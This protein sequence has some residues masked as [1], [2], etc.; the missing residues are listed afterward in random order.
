MDKA[1]QLLRFITAG[2]VDDGKSTLIGHLLHDSKS[3]FED[4][5][6]AISKTSAKRG[7]AAVDFSLLTDGLQAEREQGITI[8]VAY[9]YFATPKRKFI[10][11]D[12]PGHEQY[13]RNMVTAASTANLVVI[14]VDARKGVLVQTRRHTY[15]ASLV[16]IPHIVLAVNKMD[17]VEYSEARFSEICAEYLKFAAQLGLTDITC[18]P[19]SALVG[20][21][22]VD[23]GDNMD[24]YQGTT[25]M[26][27]LENIVI[28]HDVNTT[29]FRY[30]V[31]WVCRPQTEEHHDFRG[32]MG[33]IEAGEI[34]VG[35][36][37][38]VLPSGRTSKVKEIVT[39]DGKLQRAYAPQSVTLTLEDEIDISRGDMFV[40]G[41]AKPQVA[42]EF[43]AMLCWLSETP[44]NKNRKYLVKHTTRTAKCLFSSINYRVDVNTLEQHSTAMLNMNDIARVEIKVQQPLVFDSYDTDRATG[45]FIVIDE[46]TNNTVAAGMI[47]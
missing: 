45:S 22:L 5:F 19:I 28:D 24:W 8:D 38:T 26:N 32:F 31:Q 33:R 15:L 1:T 20:D 21:M 47:S 46:A 14:L 42:K 6:S 27:L 13:T 3:I 30:P 29:D 9:R 37:I 7:M 44:L 34:A 41:G 4:Q 25:L 12:T 18:I 40:N 11:G 16:G 2:S 36:Q 10:I 35:D 39:Y 43:A 23:R 17:M